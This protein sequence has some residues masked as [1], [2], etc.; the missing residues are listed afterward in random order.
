MNVLATVVVAG[1]A[2]FWCWTVLNDP[3]GLFK[4]LNRWAKKTYYGNKWISC[5][6]CSGA[7]FAILAAV[8][9]RE[10]EE[11]WYRTLAIAIAAAAVTGMLGSY[12]EED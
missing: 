5:P 9:L 10:P 2:G 6:W 12:F 4:R 1:L 3:D 11:A 7:W 8:A